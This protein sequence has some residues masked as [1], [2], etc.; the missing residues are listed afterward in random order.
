M[1]LV[2]FVGTAL[3]AWPMYTIATE[4]IWQCILS[5]LV[6][7]FASGG[8]FT[9]LSTALQRSLRPARVGLGQGIFVLTYYVAAAFSGTIFG[10]LAD[11]LGWAAAGTL[12]VVLI[13]LAGALLMLAADTKSMLRRA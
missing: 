13:S 4:P 12:Q 11:A 7:A 1:L 8:L 9:N 5:F 6:G 2:S 10:T 3:V